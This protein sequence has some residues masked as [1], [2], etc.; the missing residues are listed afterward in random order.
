MCLVA[1]LQYFVAMEGMAEPGLQ[2]AK[3]DSS[4]QKNNRWDLTVFW[5]KRICHTQ[6]MSLRF[7][8]YNIREA[9]SPLG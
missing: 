8:I 5:N 1:E 6:T 2:A 3:T 9:W 7:L 4:L